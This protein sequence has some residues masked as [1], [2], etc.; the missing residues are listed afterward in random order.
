MLKRIEEA[1][2][3]YQQRFFDGR[4]VV[5]FKVVTNGDLVTIGTVDTVLVDGEGQLKA[6]VLN[7]GLLSTTQ[8]LLSMK[9]SRIDLDS[10]CITTAYI[11]QQEQV[12]SLP[13]FDADDLAAV[14]QAD[15]A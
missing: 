6:L 8:R 2:P 11:Q 15:L 1:Y 9:H 10:Q 4:D 14:D 3:D 13:V 7:L 5:G 12:D